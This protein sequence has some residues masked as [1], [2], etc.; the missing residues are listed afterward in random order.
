MKLEILKLKDKT[1]SFVKKK[2][3]TFD[4]PMRLLLTGKTGM[5]KTNILSNLLLNDNKEF[6][7]N[8]FDP[9]NIF[10][11]SNS[12]R[13]GGD[14]KLMIIINELD[15]P[16]E[17]LFENYDEQAV[18]VIYDMLVDNYNEAIAEGE[19]VKHSLFVFDD[20]SFDNSLKGRE[21]ESQMNRL[22]MNSRKFLVSVTA[23][24]QKY[25]S[26]GTGLRE[27]ASGLILGK[28]SNKQLEL[29]EADHNYLRDKKLFREMFLDNTKDKHDFLVINFSKPELYFDKNFEPIMLK[30][31]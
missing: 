5:G 6:Y 4:L 18:E 26:F 24:A 19:P 10:I 1:D 28:S 2:K 29:I 11:F 3:M 21:K 31:K 20:V 9:E 22:F 8:D 13:G 23:T 25:S 14:K 27:N 7:R 17:N 30:D 12:L 15:I 16:E